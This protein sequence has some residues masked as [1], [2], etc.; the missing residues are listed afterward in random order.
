MSTRNHR[1]RQATSVGATAIR[2][3][4]LRLVPFLALMFFVNYLDRTAIAFA[5]PNGLTTDLDLSSSEFGFAAGVF[6]VG[7]VAFEVP[8]NWMLGRV[9]ARRWLS[10]IMV[11]WG[12]VAVLF[13]WVR[14]FDQLVA[15]RLLLGIAEA[16]FF[17]GAIW[18]LTR[19]VPSA[20][21][22]RILMLFL[23]ALPV[24]SVLGAPLTGWLAGHHDSFLGLDGWRLMFFL[25]AVPAVVV[26]VVAWFYLT[27]APQDA[28]WLTPDERR[29]LID[30]LA[31][32]APPAQ[33]PGTTRSVLR[34][35]RAWMLGI[36]YFGVVYGIYALAFFLPTFV[37][38]LEP[39]L[40]VSLS[41]FHAGALAAVPYALA[42]VA[43]YACA[44][45]AARCLRVTRHIAV[46][47]GL[48][49]ASLAGLSL[50]TSPVA[51]LV[52][53]SL[54]AISIF[55][56]LPAFWTLPTQLLGPAQAGISIALVNTFG[57]CAGFAAPYLTGAIRDWTGGYATATALIAA[58]VAVSAALVV[59]IRSQPPVD[60]RP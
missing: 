21:R 4:V 52:L 12:L 45:S 55:S 58:F 33:A 11:S 27:D 60:V 2:K 19:W 42:A 30:E 22:V 54:V 37:S 1:H 7:Y 9:G 57:N 15:L 39:R 53:L 20:H 24:T 46:P 28:R 51:R 3:V 59:F 49:S 17:P 31:R 10:R 34:D 8:S 13:A 48:G 44:R 26:G 56:T 29:W 5:A 25:V 35:R 23:L 36:V 6:F 38:A 16:G 47:L 14:T 18:Y 50:I 41:P 40:G 43:M 32:E